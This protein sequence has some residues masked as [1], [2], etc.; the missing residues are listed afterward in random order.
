MFPV[1]ATNTD[2]AAEREQERLDLEVAIRRSLDES[3][4]EES[5]AADTDEEITAAT[6]SFPTTHTIHE[7]S[8]P[9]P[10][11]SS[12]ISRILSLP[13]RPV[14]QPFTSGSAQNK[15]FGHLLSDHP[16]HSGVFFP[17]DGCIIQHSAYLSHKANLTVTRKPSSSLYSILY[18]N[19]VCSFS[20][21]GMQLESDLLGRM[22]L[23]IFVPTDTH[24][25]SVSPI[26][27]CPENPSALQMT[28]YFRVLDI[29]KIMCIFNHISP[30]Y[31]KVNSVTQFH[32]QLAPILGRYRQLCQV[33]LTMPSTQLIKLFQVQERV[34]TPS[35][36][37]FLLNSINWDAK[38][39]NFTQSSNYSVLK[40]ESYDPSKSFCRLL[41]GMVH[42][43]GSSLL[44][45]CNFSIL[46]NHD[47]KYADKFVEVLYDSSIEPF[48]DNFCCITVPESG[49]V[50]RQTNV[51][52]VRCNC[53]SENMFNYLYVEQ[54]IPKYQAVERLCRK[55]DCLKR[56]QRQQRL[57]THVLAEP[58]SIPRPDNELDGSPDQLIEPGFTI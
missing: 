35:G 33:N 42:G 34:F 39:G 29:D 9:K 57:I 17:L 58:R 21:N 55:D 19:S 2:H 46:A 6:R 20:H 18:D 30:H 52:K 36:T 56:A 3:S 23:S 40:T 26:C 11:S 8:R 44:L 4:A 15:F 16:L 43:I 49:F 13:S 1:G 51:L 45:N 48:L 47:E 24:L 10:S 27:P 41:A 53:S 28:H 50:M 32:S 5:L 22:C 7:G 54:T 25:K 12:P 38:M 14:C 31:L 37:G